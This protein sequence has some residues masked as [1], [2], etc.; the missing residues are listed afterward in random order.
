LPGASFAYVFGEVHRLKLLR[1]SLQT[2]VDRCSPEANLNVALRP[3]WLIRASRS[4][5][6]G[7]VTSGGAGPGVT[8]GVGI[9]LGPGVTVGVGT[10]LGPGVTVGVG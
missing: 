8:V 10:A 7:G 4:D 2:K 1:S 6:A 3:A 5:V 9:G